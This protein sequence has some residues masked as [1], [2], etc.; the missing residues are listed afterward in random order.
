MSSQQKEY[1][2]AECLDFSTR[3]FQNNLTVLLQYLQRS[4]G[5]S[6]NFQKS[7]AWEFAF[8]EILTSRAQR[9]GHADRSYRCIFHLI[10][11]HGEFQS[12]RDATSILAML[13]LG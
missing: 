9:L 3:M 1:G 6:F 13:S 10:H 4:S 2:C 5:H 12:C 7:P 11:A 8:A